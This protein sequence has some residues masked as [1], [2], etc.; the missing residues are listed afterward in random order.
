MASLGTPVID[1]NNSTFN[2]G[3]TINLPTDAADG[4]YRV[5]AI[6]GL[7]NGTTPSVDSFS[8][9][10]PSGWTSIGG[11]NSSAT[12]DQYLRIIYRKWQSGDGDTL[13]I[14]YTGGSL[15]SVAIGVTVHGAD[16]T[17]FL[18]QTTP[19]PNR[20]NT[21][22]QW[23]C[24][25]IDTQTDLAWV[26]HVIAGDGTVGSGLVDGDIPSGDSLIDTQASATP[27]NGWGL[28]FAAREV[29]TATT[30]AAANWSTLNE[31]HIGFTFAVKPDTTPP[32]ERI[33]DGYQFLDD[34]DVPGSETALASEDTQ[35]DRAR[36]TPF[37]IRIQTDMNG[38][39]PS[40]GLKL[41]YKERS[42]PASE[43]REVPT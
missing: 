25:A 12:S 29:T 10:V 33:M 42:D 18:D 35:I 17:T 23:Q 3:R 43:W 36:E 7:P 38:D 22:A 15:A 8:V 11:N 4:D 24:P 19:A 14:T 31:E 13:A 40:E 16:P 9:D 30:V 41:M 39:P 26:F 34:D 37:H 20:P 5:V 28:G 32:V 6:V 1:F 2:T 27:S 21:N